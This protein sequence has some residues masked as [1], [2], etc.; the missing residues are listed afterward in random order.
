MKYKILITALIAIGFSLSGASHAL[1]VLKPD[2]TRSVANVEGNKLMLRDATGKLWLL[3]SDGT[4][5]T[6]DG[7][8]LYVKGGIIGAQSGSGGPPRIETGVIAPIDSKAKADLIGPNSSPAKAGIIAP[9]NQGPDKLLPAVQP[10]A[11][12]MG[13]P[14]KIPER[15]TSDLKPLPGVPGMGSP[16][17]IPE[18]ITG[19]LKPL[20]GVPG[21]PIVRGGVQGVPAP[22]DTPPRAPGGCSDLAF[23]SLRLSSHINY[24]DGTRTFFLIATIT[25][26]G[27]I[28]FP[29]QPTIVFTQDGGYPVGGSYRDASIRVSEDF[30]PGNIITVNSQYIIRYPS[31]ELPTNFEAWIGYDPVRPFAPPIDEYLRDCDR[32]NN[33]F[34]LTREAVRMQLPARS[35]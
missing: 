27:S 10:S 28:S 29:N 13:S 6:D 22:F 7:R 11:P 1:S 9:M 4:Y 19:D 16:P 3:A 25:N 5:K 35:R 12:G 21:V 18:R 8:T 24:A 32:S 30:S 23:T 33:R 14:P 26:V 17:K 20:P 15:I 2:G 34:E 31:G